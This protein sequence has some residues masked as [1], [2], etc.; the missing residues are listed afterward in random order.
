MNENNEK[1]LK[2]VVKNYRQGRLNTEKAWDKFSEISGV[3]NR[4]RQWRKYSVAA[5]FTFFICAAMACIIIF[6]ETPSGVH[7]NKEKTEKV[8]H[9]QDVHSEKETKVF[10]FDNTPI[11]IALKEISDYYGCEL[12]AEDSTKCV[13]G[14]IES[15]SPDNAIAVLEATLNIKIA[16]K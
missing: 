14:E 8:P 6:K 3:A 10:T 9:K 5:S 1:E 12:T 16:R 2:F 7:K 11:N 4:K 15:T 13:S